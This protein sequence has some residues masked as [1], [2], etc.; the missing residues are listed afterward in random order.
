M[1]FFYDSF[2]R[3]KGSS[4]LRL[5]ELVICFGVRGFWGGFSLFFCGMRVVWEGGSGAGFF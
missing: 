3:C 1:F 2:G 4:K 5:R